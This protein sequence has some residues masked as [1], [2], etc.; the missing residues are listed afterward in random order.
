[1][2]TVAKVGS[3]QFTAT[4][5]GGVGS[6]TAT[7]ASINR[8]GDLFVVRTYADAYAWRLDGYLGAALPTK[9]TQLSLPSEPQGEGVVIQGDHLLLDSEGRHT[10]VWRMQ[11]PVSLTEATAARPN[12]SDSAGAVVGQVSGPRSAGVAIP[13]LPGWTSEAAV[14]GLGAL[15]AAAFACALAPAVRRR[16]RH[17]VTGLRGLH[18]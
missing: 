14:A 4:K 1:M 6:M 5:S 8:S 13:V 7:S 16:R 17:P 10:A 15:A 18:R 11:L 2:Q 3:I 9:P 12:R